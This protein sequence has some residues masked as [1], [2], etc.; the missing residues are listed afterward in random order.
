MSVNSSSPA[1]QEVIEQLWSAMRRAGDMV[2][3][4]RSENINLRERSSILEEQNYEQQKRLISLEMNAEELLDL[5]EKVVEYEEEIARKEEQLSDSER[6][7]AQKEGTLRAMDEQA[8][9]HVERIKVLEADAAHAQQRIGEM[10]AELGFLGERS[11]SFDL[12]HDEVRRLREDK[13]IMQKELVQRNKE[14]FRHTSETANLK[15]TIAQLHNTILKQ[16]QEFRIKKQELEQVAKVEFSEQLDHVSEQ[17]NRLLTDYNEAKDAA[18]RE[19]ERT[20]NEMKT[21]QQHYEEELNIVRTDSHKEIETLRRDIDTLQ[22]AEAERQEEAYQLRRDLD[23]EKAN[24]EEVFEQILRD[25]R[26]QKELYETKLFEQNARI[27]A[28]QT[29]IAEKQEQLRQKEEYIASSDALILQVRAQA[30]QARLHFDE[31]KVLLRGDVI[32]A[33]HIVEEQL[34]ST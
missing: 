19:N 5:R 8:L 16:E 32:Q 2:L 34:R 12:L 4:V 22:L 29:M 24:A 25:A 1:I 17:Y 3:Q 33:L 20:Q 6:D 15:E 27:E 31:E 9:R 26:E 11:E 18:R 23:K 13:E 30:E 10:T 14:I 7:R 21:V 28:F